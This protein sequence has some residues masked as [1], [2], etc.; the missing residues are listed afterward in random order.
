MFKKILYIHILII[1]INFFNY[2][3]LQAA[4]EEGSF[5][6]WISHIKEL[7]LDE[8]ISQETLNSA[9]IDIERNERVIELDR[10]QPEFTL[11]LD[12]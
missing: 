8:G 12:E 6:A 9:F 2:S 5:D 11:T 10:K 3:V 1:S 7:A 4:E